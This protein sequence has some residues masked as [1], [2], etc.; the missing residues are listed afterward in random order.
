MMDIEQ[1]SDP[2]STN[3]ITSVHFIPERLSEISTIGK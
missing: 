2:E 1:V 3:T